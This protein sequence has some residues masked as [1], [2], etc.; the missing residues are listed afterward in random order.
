MKATGGYFEGTIKA[1][2]G[3]F[4][5]EIN[6][7]SGSIGGLTVE[8]IKD[9]IVDTQDIKIESNYGYIF[10]VDNESNISP[11]SLIQVLFL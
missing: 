2:D 3:Y 9:T 8:S 6:A 1:T 7:T 4:S 10:K 5:G 11:I